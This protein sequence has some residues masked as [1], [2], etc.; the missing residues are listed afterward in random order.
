M[1]NIV[2]KVFIL[3]LDRRPDRMNSMIKLMNEL[4]IKNWE[5]FSAIRPKFN[6]I[7][8]SLFKEYPRILKLNKSY[9]KGSIGCKLSHLEILKIA[10]KRNY[11]KILILEDDVE[12]I[13]DSRHIRH[14]DI[15]LREI[16]NK[17]WDILYL[18][19]N[20]TKYQNI[21]GSIFINKVISGLCTH[22]Y[23][24]NGKS[25][26][27]LIRLLEE[28]QKQIDL[29]YQDNFNTFLNCYIIIPEKF[30]Q[31]SSFSDINR[32]FI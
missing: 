7:D 4:E 16:D 6:S 14:I 9:I 18:G 11:K 2:D 13:G 23:I 10:K 30:K 21:K 20:K 17:N 31:N 1:D 22:A 19:L 26:N 25:F 15:G 32:I 24:V 5:R 28:S 12:F 27:K 3:N 29:T 8:R